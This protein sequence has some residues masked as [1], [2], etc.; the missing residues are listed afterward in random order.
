M[1]LNGGEL[2]GVQLLSEAT[3]AMMTSN[4]IGDLNIEWYT[5]YGFGF[6][7]WAATVQLENSSHVG[8]FGWDGLWNT[9]FWIDPE[10]HLVTVLLS[11][12][13]PSTSELW[14]IQPLVYQGL[15]EFRKEQPLQ[16]PV[17]ASLPRELLID[18]GLVIETGA[19]VSFRDTE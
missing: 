13:Y 5:E 1:L 8:S 3:V 12:T 15:D 7:G 17:S 10:A 16:Q 19:D 18:D 2:D 4:Q 14:N 6:G 9:T 11:Q